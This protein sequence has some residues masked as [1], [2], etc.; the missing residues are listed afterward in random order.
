MSTLRLRRLGFTLIELLVVIAIIAVL[1]AILLPAVQQ[2]REAARNS[3]C[4]NNLKQ[5]GVAMHNY[6]ETYGMFPRG[7]QGSIYDG[8]GDGWRSFSAH[9]MLLPYMDQGALYNKINLN[10]NS[11]CENGGGPPNNEA[12]LAPVRIAGFRCPSDA[13]PQ[14]RIDWNNYVISAGATRG[15]NVERVAENGIGNRFTWVTMGDITDGSSNVLMF[16]EIVTSDQG[17]ATGTQTDLARVREGSGIGPDGGNATQ[18]YPTS[19]TKATVDGWVNSCN[20]IA[21]INGNRVGE[22]WY[23]GQFYRT[24]FNTLLTPN[25]KNASCTFHCG[26]CH[27]DG[28]GMFPARS[29]HTGGVNALM[30][31]G[32]ATFVSENVDWDVWNRFGSRNDGQGTPP[33]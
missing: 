26:G 16:S 6:H 13:P 4:K 27:Y 7:I 25:S 5:F 19:I 29:K 10:A 22:K 30:C 9:V 14:D 3:Q 24:M 15:F 21:G 18:A 8:S 31:D 32:S 11:C 23:H 2:A 17:G 33:L 1:V 12:I 28:S 20:G